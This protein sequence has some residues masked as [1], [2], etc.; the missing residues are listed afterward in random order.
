MTQ[1]PAESRLSAFAGGQA[2]RGLN[3]ATSLQS[4]VDPAFH[5]ASV[6]N[7][8]N[9]IPSVNGQS[10]TNYEMTMPMDAMMRAR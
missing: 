8:A 1:G 6:L 5:P 2:G 7:L 9:L 3:T 10:D 4:N